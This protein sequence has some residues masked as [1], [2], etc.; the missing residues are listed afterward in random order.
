MRMVVME[1]S[2]AQTKA[3][4]FRRGGAGSASTADVGSSGSAMTSAAP[5]CSV[6]PIWLWFLGLSLVRT[7]E[8]VAWSLNISDSSVCQCQL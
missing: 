3:N 5:W 2:M 7:T 8:I 4:M 6:V 1:A